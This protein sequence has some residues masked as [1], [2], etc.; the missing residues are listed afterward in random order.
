MAG[1]FYNSEN[2]YSTEKILYNS[3]LNKAFSS[4]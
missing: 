3:Y 4:R 1:Q 2:E